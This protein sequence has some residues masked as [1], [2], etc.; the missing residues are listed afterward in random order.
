MAHSVKCIGESCHGNDV[1][2]R[3]LKGFAAGRMQP[4]A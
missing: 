3:A 2:E 1:Q 4:A